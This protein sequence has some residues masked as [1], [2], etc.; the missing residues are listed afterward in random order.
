[1]TAIPR[2]S[3]SFSQ[4]TANATTYYF[5]LGG[6]DAGLIENVHITW[7]ATFVGTI[8]IEGSNFPEVAVTST[9]VGDW[10]PTNPTTAAYVVDTVG[11]GVTPT[12]LS[13]AVAGGAAGGCGINLSYLGYAR[14]RVKLISTTGGRVRAV[15]HAKC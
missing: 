9:T 4:T 8:T 2:P 14:G 1:M 15:C 10:I 3:D 5:G 7:D 12:A 13:I 6:E 11:A